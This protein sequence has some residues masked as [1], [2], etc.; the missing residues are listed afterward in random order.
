[1][2]D[3]V[4]RTLLDPSLNGC[5]LCNKAVS[6]E[7]RPLGKDSSFAHTI[8]I[9]TEDS[10]LPSVTT[11]FSTPQK[12]FNMSSSLRIVAVVLVSALISAVFYACSTYYRG[13]QRTPLK[14]LSSL[15]F[16]QSID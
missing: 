6:G 12:T 10:Y 1:M 9:C 15:S 13:I 11:A 2:L 5:S 4:E 8:D 14:L 3:G 7:I 16:Q